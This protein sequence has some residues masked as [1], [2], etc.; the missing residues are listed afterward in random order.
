MPNTVYN[1]RSVKRLSR[2]RRALVRLKE[3]GYLRVVSD[4][5]GEASGVTS[6][7]VRKDFS[8]FGISGNKKGGYKI[9]DLLQSLEKILGKDRVHKVIV[10]GAGNIGTA[11]IN[12][13]KFEEEQIQIV[14]AFDIDPAKVNRKRKIP[15]YHLDD[16]EEFV[17][18]NGIKTGIIAVPAISAQ[19]VCN[20]MLSIG[21]RGILNFAPIRLKVWNDTVITNVNILNKLENIFYFVDGFGKNA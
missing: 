21:I 3:L 13:K 5:L 18:S 12:Y 6:S 15:I 17:M 4:T 7:Q 1:K 14:A 20:R 10:I 2:Y 11:L 9:D 8:I 19:E 16:L